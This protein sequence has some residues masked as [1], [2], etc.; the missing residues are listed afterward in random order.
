[1]PHTIAI[2]ASGN[3]SNAQAIFDAIA[4]GTLTARVAVLICNRPGARVLDRARAAGVP[5]LEMNHKDWPDREQFD[6]AMVQALREHSVDIVVL[7]GYMRLLSPVFLQAFPG[8]IINLHPALLPAFPGVDGVAD[9]RAWGVRITGCTVH[10]VDEAMDHGEIILQ[11]ALPVLPEDTETTLRQRIQAVEHRI[12]PQA[13]QWAVEGRLLR[14]GRQV[15]LLPGS[16][17]PA[18]Q[19]DTCLVS[20]PLEEGF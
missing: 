14:K 1:M 12:F 16:K 11:A 19:P 9:A 20:P 4:R 2:L 10:F 5:V 3:G 18:I 15:H 17:K 13:V 7:A 6:A 8:R